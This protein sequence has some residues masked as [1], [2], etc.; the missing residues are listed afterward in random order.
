MRRRM[1]VPRSL[2]A[3]GKNKVSCTEYAY[4]SCSFLLTPPEVCRLRQPSAC[5]ATRTN[6]EQTMFTRALSSASA[7]I[8]LVIDTTVPWGLE[9]GTVGD[10]CHNA[11][12]ADFPIDTMILDLRQNTPGA[13]HSSASLAKRSQ[14]PDY[15]YPLLVIIPR[16]RV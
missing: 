13:F 11:D 16:T 9:T 2:G 6:L 14:Y 1:L 8:P 3:S 4:G 10:T 12:D 7:L 15:K 5:R